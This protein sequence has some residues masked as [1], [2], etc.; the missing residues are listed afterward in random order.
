[1][2]NSYGKLFR[3]SLFGESHSEA[4]GVV[5]DGVPSGIELDMNEI[6]FE[7][8]RRAPGRDAF[9]TPRAEGDVPRILSGVFNGITTG[10]PICA[11]IKNINTRSSDYHAEIIRPSHADYSGKLR[12]NGFNDYRGG[13]HFSGRL[14]AP[15][16]FAGAIAKQIIKK[17]NIE[18]FSHIK[19][20]GEVYDDVVDCVNPDIDVLKGLKDKKLAFINNDKMKDAEEE[21]LSA[22]G[23][24]DSIGGSIETVI[25]G[26]AGGI[27]SPFFESV[28]S[29]LASMLFSVPAVKAVEFGIGRDFSEILG[30]EANDSFV[31]ENG[32]IST[33][34]NNNGGIN[35]GITNGMPVVFSVT[36]KPTPSI[37]K[38]QETVN[39]ET[40]ENITT[41]I[42]GRHDPCIVQRAVPVIEAATAIVLLDLILEA[43]TY[44]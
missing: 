6:M 41:K 27:G 34:T 42:A 32:K 14:T 1:M 10:T 20:I 38:E 31:I 30:S 17:E 15:I 36:I 8:G 18:I 13:G 7:M 2:A 22:K 11:V 19:N 35:G 23:N 4:I 44:A 26:I 29:R 21:I 3:I 33:K 5:I 40:N 25:T 37:G 9:S 39:V 28:E 16:V 12:Y 43:K 24:A